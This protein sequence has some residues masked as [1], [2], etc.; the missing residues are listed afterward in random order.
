MYE[1]FSER[2][3]SL[4]ADDPIRIKFEDLSK[5]YMRQ[6]KNDEGQFENVPAEIM[7][8]YQYF[9]N[10]SANFSTRSIYKPHFC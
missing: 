6:F 2:I 8:K 10:D 7:A 9:T 1:L 5:K 3:K 4:S